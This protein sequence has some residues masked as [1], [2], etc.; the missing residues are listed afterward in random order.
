MLQMLVVT[1]REGIE[2]FLIVAIAITYLR[3]T[4]RDGLVT[5]AWWGADSGG[6]RGGLAALFCTCQGSCFIRVRF[7]RVSSLSPVLWGR[8]LLVY[9]FRGATEPTVLAIK[10]Q[11]WPI[12]T[13]P[14]GPE[15]QY[16]AI[17]TY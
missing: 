14:Y 5:A 9:P 12:F 10:N 7:F 17:L 16:G 13:V 15:G 1:L 3:K 4:G 2:A 6:G 8:Q 11:N